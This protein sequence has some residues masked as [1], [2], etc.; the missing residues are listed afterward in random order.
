MIILLDY[1]FSFHYKCEFQASH[2]STGYKPGISKVG[3]LGQ[4]T[5]EQ[6]L[7]TTFESHRIFFMK[8]INQR[9]QNLASF[10]IHRL[11]NINSSIQTILYV[12]TCLPAIQQH[13]PFRIFPEF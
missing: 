8:D 9:Q 11:P 10:S 4:F 12:Q 2:I 5:Y 1:L 6:K 3:S 13:V 7:S